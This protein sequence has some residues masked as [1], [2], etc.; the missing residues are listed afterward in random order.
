MVLFQIELL[1]ND[2]KQRR[3]DP[4]IAKATQWGYSQ[5]FTY[6]YAELSSLKLSEKEYFS[7]NKLRYELFKL[8]VLKLDF[9]DVFKNLVIG[10][11]SETQNGGLEAGVL[12]TVH[13]L[14]LV[15]QKYQSICEIM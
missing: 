1:L 11:E 6:S 9:T 12:F 2:E 10:L 7:Y 4:L 8:L 15:A 14:K 13:S 5:A 3:L